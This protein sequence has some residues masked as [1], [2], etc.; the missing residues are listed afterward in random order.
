MVAQQLKDFDKITAW[1]KL[2]TNVTTSA[3]YDIISNNGG[4]TQGTYIFTLIDSGGNDT[5]LARGTIYTSGGAQ[6][7]TGTTKLNDSAW[8]HI[9]FV[10]NTS[11]TGLVIYVDG[12][13]DNTGT[14]TYSGTLA[15]LTA[16]VYLGERSAGTT[17]NFR[18]TMDDVR[19]YNT[20][21][22][23]TEITTLYNNV[24]QVRGKLVMGINETTRKRI[25]DEIANSLNNNLDIPTTS[26][27]LRNMLIGFGLWRATLIARTEVHRTASWA[28]EQTALQMNIAGTIKEWVAV[29]DDRTRITHAVADGQKQNIESKFA[30]GGDL[31]KYPGDP[32]GSPEETINCRCVVTYTTPDYFVN[33]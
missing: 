25:Q 23:S 9:A 11:G 27:N 4:T 18:G 1:V 30:I 20:A 3:S 14:V 29:Q 32:M 19:I 2:V 28:N 16:N 8:H 31:L 7:V 21:L 13:K 15:A 6:T 33:T 24:N 17:N 26:K 5:V 22:T 10:L 12:A